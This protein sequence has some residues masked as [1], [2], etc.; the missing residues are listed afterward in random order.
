MKHFVRFFFVALCAFALSSVRRKIC[1]QKNR[2]GT[3][4]T[5]MIFR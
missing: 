3:I 2:S 4:L 5:A 1:R